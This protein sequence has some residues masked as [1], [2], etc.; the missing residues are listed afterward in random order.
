MLNKI[1]KL[2]KDLHQNP[3]LSGKEINTAKRIKAFINA[4]NPTEIIENIGGN[5]LAAIYNFSDNGPVVM[6]RCELDALPISETN[7][8]DHRS[9]FEN[10]SHKC[11]HDGHMAIVAGLIFW[12]KKQHFKKGKIILLFQPAEETGKG[13]KAV[14]DDLKFEKLKPDYVFALHNIPGEK[15]HSIILPTTHFSATVCS[16]SATLT[17]KRAH[18]SE[19]EN[20]INPTLALAKIINRLNKLV[21][22]KTSSNHFALL[23]PIHILM[24]EKS[25]GISPG[26]GEI[27]YTIRTW[28]DAEMEI[29]QKKIVSIISDVCSEYKLEFSIDWFD[30]FPASVNDEFCRNIVMEASKTN[31]LEI[32]KRD[33]AFKFG[34]DFGWFSKNHKAAMFGLGSGENCP[35]LHHADYDFPE[36]IIETGMQMFQSIISQLLSTQNS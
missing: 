24:G 6:I 32:V 5:G 15:L 14:L 10:I 2:R 19:P 17:G 22:A 33:E 8:F 27:H 23:T 29:L 30:Y 13:A 36:G 11:G 25:Y 28:N 18:A 9:A 3:E 26:F 20:G 7:T 4:H 34:E 35:A 31:K 21:V 1:K 12:I 16:F